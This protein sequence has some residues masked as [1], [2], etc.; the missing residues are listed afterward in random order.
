MK[1][2]IWNLKCLYSSLLIEVIHLND[3]IYGALLN[4]GVPLREKC[5]RQAGRQA[6]GWF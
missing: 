2:K 1:Q 4:G 3:A 6:C 5:G